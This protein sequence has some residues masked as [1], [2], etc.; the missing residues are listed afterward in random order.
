MEQCSSSFDLLALPSQGFAAQGN[1]FSYYML[2][3]SSF[4]LNCSTEPEQVR[5]LACLAASR[6]SRR[7]H[8]LNS[9]LHNAF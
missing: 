8:T 2:I 5:C 7:P 9:E 3:T 4:M 1:E 6:Q